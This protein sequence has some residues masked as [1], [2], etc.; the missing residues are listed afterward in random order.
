MFELS[1]NV[2]D[3]LGRSF[4]RDASRP[5]GITAQSARLFKQP[6][7]HPRRVLQS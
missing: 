2:P 7:I 4:G 5:S 6:E 1:I 3:I